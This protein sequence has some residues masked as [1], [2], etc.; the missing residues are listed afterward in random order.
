AG[1]VTALINGDNFLEGLATGAV[2]G[3]AVAAVNYTV[4]YY[5]KY[6]RNK[7]RVT[8]ADNTTSKYKYDPT[9]GDDTMQNN[10]NAARENFRY[11]DYGVG[12]ETVGKAGWLDGSMNPGNNSKVLAYTTKAGF[13]SNK[14]NIVYSPLVAQNPE[15]LAETML[16]E[17]G[18]AFSNKL[19]LLSQI[20]DW[21][22]E[23][24]IEN[25]YTGALSTTEEF[26]VYKLE[27]I[28]KQLNN[29]PSSDFIPQ[30]RLDR[31]FK[32]LDFARQSL[33]NTTY[34]K[35]M[36]VFNRYMKY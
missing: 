4:N 36:P 27:H 22:N 31:M 35:L 5:V 12:D 33:I 2:I 11:T 29:F 8:I 14:S 10:I 23:F 18:H 16:H 24:G 26:A 25:Q 32:L 17:T 1:G 20:I 9:I 19:G 15:L 7:T 28:S 34:E 3:G 6:S 30:Y 13:F 21:K